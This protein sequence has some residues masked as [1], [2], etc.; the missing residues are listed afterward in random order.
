MRTNGE[1]ANIPKPYAS[2]MQ[3]NACVFTA[4]R[5]V[6]GAACPS[7]DIRRLNEL[8]K[9]SDTRCAPPGMF[10]PLPKALIAH[11]PCRQIFHDL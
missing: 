8:P 1:N 4:N 2:W 6:R 3:P 9:S 11:L 10:I 5:T 7:A